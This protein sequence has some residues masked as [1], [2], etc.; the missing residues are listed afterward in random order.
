[1]VLIIIIDVLKRNNKE[2]NYLVDSDKNTYIFLSNNK[3]LF[4]LLIGRK[5]L[6]KM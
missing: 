5:V 2:V 6:F 1:M 3:F 4:F